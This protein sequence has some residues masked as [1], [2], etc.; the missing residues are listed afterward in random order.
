VREAVKV[1]AE[2]NGDKPLRQMENEQDSKHVRCESGIEHERPNY[3]PLYVIAQDE[4]GDEL[5]SHEQNNPEQVKLRKDCIAEVCT[6]ISEYNDSATGSGGIHPEML[7]R[8]KSRDGGH[9]AKSSIQA[10]DTQRVNQP[11]LQR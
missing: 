10:K 2:P 1:S 7:N 9:N 5:E 8:V 3:L 6:A 4:V 11:V